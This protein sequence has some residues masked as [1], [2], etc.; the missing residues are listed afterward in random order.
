M[1]A[2]VRI[3]VVDDEKLQREILS[4]HLSTCG[5][6]INLAENGEKALAAL[7]DPAQIFD[8]VLTDLKMP[9]IDGIEVVKK[10]RDISPDTR[11]LVATA[12]GSID[13]AIQAIKA[14]A[15]DYLQKP[16]EFDDL[17]HRLRQIWQ[18]RPLQTL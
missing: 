18:D 10:G 12:H 15:S 4:E 5:Y 8:L 7:K 2:P 17:D 9:G 6:E 14:G 1:A 16:I 3:L 11:F 13:T